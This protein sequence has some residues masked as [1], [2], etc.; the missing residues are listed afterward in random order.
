[1]A[2]TFSKPHT[3]N[4]LITQPRDIL[5][6]LSKGFVHYKIPLCVESGAATKLRTIELKFPE[7]LLHLDTLQHPERVLVD[8]GPALASALAEAPAAPR[9]GGHETGECGMCLQ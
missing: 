1:L 7:M 9:R 8:I 3:D 4:K 2:V 5:V 6:R